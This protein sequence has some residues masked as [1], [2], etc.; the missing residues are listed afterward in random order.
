MT[1]SEASLYPYEHCLLRNSAVPLNNFL[2]FC[3]VKQVAKLFENDN[4]G[5]QLANEILA[6]MFES[7]IVAENNVNDG[8]CKLEI[9]LFSWTWTFKAMF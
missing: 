4:T 6:L 2:I 1:M 8:E 3:W 7:Q 9:T 5:M